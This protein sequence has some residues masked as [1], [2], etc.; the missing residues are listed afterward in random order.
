[1]LIEQPQLAYLDAQQT[2]Q[3]LEVFLKQP[4]PQELPPCPGCENHI[5]SKCSCQCPDAKRALSTEPD[6]HPIETSVVPLVYGLMST[7]LSQT[8]WSCEGHMDENNRLISLPRV[9]FYTSSPVYSQLLHRHLAKLMLDKKL[10]YNWHVTL[11][12][13]AQTWGQTYS[14]T[15]DLN[16]VNGDVHLGALQNDLK[17]IAEDLL[18]KM[19][20][21]AHEM[22]QEI[23]RWLKN[24]HVKNYA[25]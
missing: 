8:I 23:D 19:K 20:Q 12:D 22:L 24:S 2:R 14:I 17:V 4:G 3:S 15:P 25:E 6:S 5:K 21:I 1:M 10:V 18:E 13:Y 7:R 9:S 11:T 16:F